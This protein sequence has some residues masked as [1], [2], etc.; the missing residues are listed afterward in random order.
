MYFFEKRDLQKIEKFLYGATLWHQILVE[1][2]EGDTIKN[3]LNF[4]ELDI[5]LEDS[6]VFNWDK[7]KKYLNEIR[8]NL[9]KGESLDFKIASEYIDEVQRI[10]MI[11]EKLIISLKDN[12]IFNEY[13]NVGFEWWSRDEYPNYELLGS[14]EMSDLFLETEIWVYNSWNSR[15]KGWKIYDKSDRSDNKYAELRSLASY[16]HDIVGSEVINI[17]N[18]LS[19]VLEPYILAQKMRKGKHLRPILEFALYVYFLGKINVDKEIMLNSSNDSKEQYERY[20]IIF[21][22][23]LGYEKYKLDTVKVR[24]ESFRFALDNKCKLTEDKQVEKF[25]NVRDYMLYHLPDKKDEILSV[26][27]PYLQ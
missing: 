14:I 8:T 23:A 15:C 17:D 6:T 22:N 20:I 7:D 10:K 16:V 25:Q 27:E 24:L 2:L 18:G 12:F 3:A 21:N 26:F 13:S 11:G 1:E 4:D 19:A 5:I 9:K